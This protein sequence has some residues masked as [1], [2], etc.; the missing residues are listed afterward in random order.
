MK[1]IRGDLISLVF[2]PPDDVHI[3]P[4]RYYSHH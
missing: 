3:H 1:T 4:S 2:Y